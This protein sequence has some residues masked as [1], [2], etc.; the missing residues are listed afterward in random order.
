MQIQ[1]LFLATALG[2]A[3]TGGCNQA[4]PNK[5]AVQVSEDVKSD[6]GA[7]LPENSV[8]EE[9]QE[10]VVETPEFTL[11]LPATWKIMK[12]RDTLL[13]AKAPPE[14][15]NDAFSENVRVKLYSLP[16]AMTPKEIL[17]LQKKDLGSFKYL[18]EGEVKNSL[19]PFVWLAISLKSPERGNQEFTK[20]DYITV[21]GQNAIVMHAVVETELWRK[22]APL[23]E[24][25]AR[26][27]KL[28]KT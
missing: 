16:E 24:R 1:L 26:T 7:A 15:E 20:I 28:K 17:L 5:D 3:I 11:R 22:K 14:D 9:L 8:A 10:Q 2:I 25:I 19:S 18:D 23:F 6:G 27:M 13:S 4:A 12:E 21:N